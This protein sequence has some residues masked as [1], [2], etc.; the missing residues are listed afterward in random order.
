MVRLKMNKEYREAEFSQKEV[1]MLLFLSDMDSIKELMECFNSSFLMGFKRI[2]LQYKQQNIVLIDVN[3][4][5]REHLVKILKEVDRY[6]PRREDM[7]Q[8]VPYLDADIDEIG[9]EIYATKAYLLSNMLLELS[10]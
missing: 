2:S 9:G 8:Y 1:Q 4:Y 5:S 6:V 3:L 7:A 10:S